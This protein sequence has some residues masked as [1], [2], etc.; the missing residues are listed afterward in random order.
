MKYLIPLL[1]LIGCGPVNVNN[2][3]YQ[4]STQY[5]CNGNASC[6][7]ASGSNP[8][9]G[10]I[11]ADSLASCGWFEAFYDAAYPSIPVTTNLDGTTN[12]AIPGA[13][14]SSC[15][16]GFVYSSPNGN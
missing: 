14:A 16:C 5:N 12:P 9:S 3:I 1:L 6:I 2:P 8:T 7:A 13:Y 11:I 10:T 15:T 4:C